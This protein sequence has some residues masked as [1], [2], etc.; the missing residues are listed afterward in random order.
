LCDLSGNVSELGLGLGR[1][2]VE[3]V[4]DHLEKLAVLDGHIVTSL[5]GAG[6]NFGLGRSEGRGLQK[7]TQIGDC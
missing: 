2:P 4:H 5:K 6:A 1:R 3:A 7:E